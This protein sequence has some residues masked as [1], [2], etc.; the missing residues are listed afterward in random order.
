MLLQGYYFSCMLLVLYMYIQPDFCESAEICSHLSGK[1]AK[2]PKI[3]LT[4]EKKGKIER[5]KKKKRGDEKIKIVLLIL[6]MAKLE[7]VFERKKR[8]LHQKG[9]FGIIFKKKIPAR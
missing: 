3:A 4:K 8:L 5:A 1:G 7:I 2:G 9:L 6:L